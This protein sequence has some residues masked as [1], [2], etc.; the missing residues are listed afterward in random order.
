MIRILFTGGGTGGHIYPIVAVAEELKLKFI[1]GSEIDL[2]Y[3]GSPESFRGLL[4]N[5]GVKVSKIISAKLR[6]YFDLRNFIEI[7]FL[8][9]LSVIQAIWKV[10][11]IMPDVLFSKGGPGSLPV[12]L[13]CKFYRVPII[14][15]DSDTVPGLANKLAARFANRIAVSFASA[16]VL[17]SA[18]NP[19]LEN[20]IALIGNPIR[21]SLFSGEILDKETAKKIFGFNP[22]KPVILIICGSQG[23]EK[24]NDFIIETAGELIKNWQILHQTGIK[25]FKNV[26]QELDSIFPPEAGSPLAKKNY[27]EKLK[28]NYKTFPY[29]EKDLKDAYAAADLVIS[30][31]SGGSIFEIAAFAKP[32]L[33]IPLPSEVVGAHQ[34]KNAYEYAKTG[35]AVIIE[36]ENLKPDIFLFQLKKLFSEPEKLNQMS[37]AAKSFSKPEAARIIAEE[38]IKL[39]S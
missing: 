34:I 14:I 28:A 29:F 21:N 15:H 8:F 19:K 11:W 2:R 12:V 35:S 16:G 36:Q 24:I 31:A 5:N 39:T 4:E 25:N 18:K 32:S 20:K 3:L 1:E 26:K 27:S 30:R 9:P 23:A 37:Q 22:K 38:I 6:R 17:L 13:A 33:L 7:P 10:F